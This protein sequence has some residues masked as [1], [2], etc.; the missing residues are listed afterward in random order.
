MKNA[1]SNTGMSM[2]MPAMGLI[3]N[4]RPATTAHT[5]S[6]TYSDALMSAPPKRFSTAK[7]P[8]DTIDDTTMDTVMTLMNSAALKSS[9]AAAGAEGGE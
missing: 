9:V 1:I 7:A 8:M 3:V 2:M 6:A 5:T 4:M